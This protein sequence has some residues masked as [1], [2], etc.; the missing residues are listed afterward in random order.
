MFYAMQDQLGEEDVT[1]ASLGLVEVTPAKNSNETF[2]AR[3][4]PRMSERT[5]IH[6]MHIVSP[7][8]HSSPF[9]RLF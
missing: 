3:A 7:P 4:S 2:L 6:E 5:H 1:W 9:A 8:T